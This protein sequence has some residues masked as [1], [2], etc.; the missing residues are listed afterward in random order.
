MQEGGGG[1]GPGHGGSRPRSARSA[2]LG[3][4]V[5]RVCVC[6][7]CLCVRAHTRLGGSMRIPAR[8]PEASGR[9][10]LPGAA[11]PRKSDAHQEVFEREKIHH[12]TYIKSLPD[13]APAR[14]S[15]P[16][17]QAAG[18][19]PQAPGRAAVFERQQQAIGKAS[20]SGG[21]Y[22]QHGRRPRDRPP[23]PASRC[24]PPGPRSREFKSVVP[25]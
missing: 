7:V 9:L 22:E 14:A 20:L 4:C 5:C 12:G 15:H 6:V 18:P 19:R 17:P 23:R 2:P 21:I 16:D 10:S 24:P 1:Q 11:S 13:G 8:I 3:L 25:S